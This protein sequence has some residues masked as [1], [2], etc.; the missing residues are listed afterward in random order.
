MTVREAQPS[1]FQAMAEVMAAAFHDEEFF[2]V[3][4]HPHRTQYPEDF[5]RFFYQ[6]LW[7][8]WYEWNYKFL[9]S[10]DASTK[11]G[12]VLGVGLWERQ[13]EGG[14]KMGLAVYDP[15]EF[16]Y[17][18]PSWQAN[19]TRESGNLASLYNTITLRASKWFSP[20]RAADP[21]HANV[22]HD[23]FP[24]IK[25]Y[26]SGKREENWYLDFL[27]V[28]PDAQGKGCGKELV[29]WGVERAKRDGVPAS[30]VAALDKEGFYG[31]LGFVEVGRANVGPMGEA[32]IQGGAVMFNDGDGK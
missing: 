28:H 21:A 26:W 24:L 2:G 27:A 20:N 1:D 32:G 18:H 5:T 25:H 7:E 4:M 8:H 10:V 9:V 19:V 14:R 31:K 12:K 11:N 17:I 30:V 6:K 13:G 23:T 22:L 16:T 29:L 15:R 3:L